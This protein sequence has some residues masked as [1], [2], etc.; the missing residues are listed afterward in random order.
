MSASIRKLYT[1]RGLTAPDGKGIHTFA[2][3]K[4]AAGLLRRGYPRR[5]AYSIAMGQLGRDKMVKRSHWA[6]GK[7]E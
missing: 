7:K 6:E 2:F 5:R 3:H 4:I 1:S